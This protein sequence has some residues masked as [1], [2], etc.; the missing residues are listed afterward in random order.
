MSV[1]RSRFIEHLEVGGYSPRTIE[2]YVS[3]VFHLS[4]HYDAS[5]LSISA[6]QIRSY[7]RH[8]LKVKK[9]KASTVRLK[10]GGLKTFYK[11]ADVSPSPMDSIKPPRRQKFLPTVLSLSEV[12]QLIN[13]IINPKHR[14]AI[15]LLYTSGLRLSELC[16]LKIDDIDSK[17]MLVRVRKG[18][19]SKERFTILSQYALVNLR[20]YVR[21]YSPKDWLFVGRH[22]GQ[23]SCRM[24]SNVIRRSSAKAKLKKKISPHTLRHSFATHMLEQGTSLQ[25]IQKLLGHSSLTTTTLYTHVSQALVRKVVSPIDLPAEENHHA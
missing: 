4:Q 19:G 23:M 24:V 21:L 2:N 8:L 1:L 20:H 9:L 22:G 12:K 11:F 15:T 5:P 18:K 14:A 17:Q 25:I 13:C 10:I 7:L 3:A 16:D 6:D